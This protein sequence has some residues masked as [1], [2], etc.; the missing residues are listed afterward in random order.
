[1]L[2]S[3]KSWTGCLQSMSI[4]YLH[5]AISETISIKYNAQCVPV[6]NN[7]TC[8]WCTCH[9]SG[10]VMSMGSFR[11]PAICTVEVTETIGCHLPAFPAGPATTKPHATVPRTSCTTPAAPLGL[12]LL[13]SSFPHPSLPPPSPHPPRPPSD[14]LPCYDRT[15]KSPSLSRLL[16]SLAITDVARESLLIRKVPARSPPRVCF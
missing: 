3:L 11:A 16:P 15:I 14:S 2:K 13:S 1:M 12:T 5:Q 9:L 7:L 8:S 6:I 4:V 10:D